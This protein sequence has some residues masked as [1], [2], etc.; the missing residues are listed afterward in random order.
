M[1]K[2]K[3][4]K[5]FVTAMVGA[6]VNITLNFALIPNS[7]ELFGLVIPCAGWGAQGAAIATMIS[8]ATVFVIRAVDTKRLMSFRLG[9]LSLAL[10]S[11]VI[12][13]QIVTML[14]VDSIL[15][16]AVCQAVCVAAIVA[17]NAKTLLFALRSILN[18]LRGR[19]KVTK[20]DNIAQ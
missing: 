9:A 12:A 2:K 5:S 17:V 20:K 6:L 13:V 16:L 4:V 19:K 1:V 11:A 15:I 10:N 7:L 14:F 18:A 8:Y 3:S